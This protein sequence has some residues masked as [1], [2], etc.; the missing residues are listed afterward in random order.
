MASL[1]DKLV[2]VRP[3]MGKLLFMKCKTQKFWYS[4]RFYVVAYGILEQIM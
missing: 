3:S 4:Q 1:Y 2:S